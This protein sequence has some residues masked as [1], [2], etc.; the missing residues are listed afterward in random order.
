MTAAEILTETRRLGIV[1]LAD[2]QRLR[3]RAPKCLM[4][5]EL[6]EALAARK[7]ELLALLTAEDPE[8]TWRFTIMERQVPTTGPIPILVARSV[9]RRPGHCVSCGEAVPMALSGWRRCE[10]CSRAAWLA[11]MAGHLTETRT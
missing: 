9:Q 4:T 2:G 10:P 5:P 11:I 8:V 3:Y 1:L 7:P 6:R